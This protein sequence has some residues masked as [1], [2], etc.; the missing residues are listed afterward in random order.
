MIAKQKTSLSDY[1]TDVYS[2]FHDIS[3]DSAYQLKRSATIFENWAAGRGD[4]LNHIGAITDEAL[5]LCLKDLRE[6]YAQATLRKMRGDW[7]T[8][9]KAA[10]AD[11]LCVEPKKV[12]SIAKPKPKPRA[13]T[14]TQVEAIVESALK[15]EGRSSV[16]TIELGRFFAAI[17][18]TAWDTGLRKQDLHELT[19]EMVSADGRVRITQNKTDDEHFCRISADTLL[20][21]RSIQR[22]RPLAWP[23]ADCQFYYHWHRII[24]RAKVP[25]LGAMHA[26]RK[27]G[28]TEVA[29]IAPGLETRFLGHT[30]P[31]ADAHYVDKSLAGGAAPMP[32]PL[33]MPKSGKSKAV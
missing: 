2:V 28:S 8:L 3:R 16:H 1:A 18:A 23:G 13:W 6:Q 21:L 30:S 7:L 29:R 33:R 19:Q 11:E 15:Y 32:T 12:R 10:A 27:S 31:Q 4:G 25:T 26:I 17:V 22:R 24:E 14:Q 9:L 5:S 20:L